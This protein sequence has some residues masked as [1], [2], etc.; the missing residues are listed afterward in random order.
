MKRVDEVQKLIAEKNRSGLKNLY[1][2]LFKGIL[3]G[4]KIDGVREITF[5][6][7][8]NEFSYLQSTPYLQTRSS[9]NEMGDRVKMG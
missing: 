3:V 8:S 4:K 1:R 2:S 6:L 5:E 9:G 7:I